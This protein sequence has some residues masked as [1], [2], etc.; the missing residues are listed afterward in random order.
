MYS[1]KVEGNF[2]SA[3][4]LRG[5]KGKCEDL[6]GHNWKVEVTI[7]SGYLDKIGLLVD[8]RKAKS[9]LKSVLNA[10]DHKRIDNVPYF[11][12]RNPTSEIVAEYIFSRYKSK[13]KPP[14]ALESVSVW[15]TPGSCATYY[16]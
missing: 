2:S 5:Y 16:E 14:M 9:M 6:H 3:H 15:E 13:I 10:L 11:K 4:N 12:K 8:F 1:I 7:A